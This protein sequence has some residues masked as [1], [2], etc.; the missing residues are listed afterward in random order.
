[1]LAKSAVFGKQGRGIVIFVVGK[2]EQQVAMRQGV[3]GFER[4]G[5][6]ACCLAFAIPSQFGQRD[7]EIEQRLLHVG[8][9]RQR[10]A[11]AG[12]RFA[13]SFLSPQD[14][15]QVVMGSFEIRPVLQGAAQRRFRFAEPALI[16]EGVA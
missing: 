6:S 13:E 12:F 9:D 7:A 11:V 4:H 14:I 8:L 15:A 10:L 5:L 16:I 1:L 2:T 3:I